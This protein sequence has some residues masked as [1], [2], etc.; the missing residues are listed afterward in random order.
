MNREE[1]VTKEVGRERKAKQDQESC[2]SPF[3]TSIMDNAYLKI[4]Y[5]FICLKHLCSALC[6]SVAV[7]KVAY[8]IY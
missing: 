8:N 6:P 2:F 1:P 3:V 7:P 5:P 4:L